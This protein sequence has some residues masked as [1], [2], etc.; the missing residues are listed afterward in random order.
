MD[1]DA[2]CKSVCI[3]FAQIKMHDGGVRTLIEVCHVPELKKILYL[4]VPWIQMVSLAG[5][6]M[7]LFILEENESLW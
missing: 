4:W 1:N 2:P 6:K 3:G 5:L 7:G